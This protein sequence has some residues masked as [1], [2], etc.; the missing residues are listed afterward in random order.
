MKKIL[1]LCDGDNFPSGATRFIRQMRENEPLYVKG[2]FMDPIDVLEMIPV[3][4]I[5]ISAPYERLIQEEKQRVR[6]SQDQFVEAFENAGIK[7]EI[8]P[9]TG[10]WN[11]EL[12]IR[13]SRFC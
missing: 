5:P 2:L 1:L 12:F 4:F 10:E 7:Y 6:K 11:R 9:H 8:H 13:E 3:G